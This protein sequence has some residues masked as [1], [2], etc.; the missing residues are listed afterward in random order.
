M[1][2]IFAVVILFWAVFKQ[3]GS[4]LNTWADRYTDREV[5]GTMAT[6][7]DHLKFSKKLTYAKDSIDAYDDQFRLIKEDG[8]VKLYGSGLVSSHGEAK[9]ALE[10]QWEAKGKPG[11][12]PCSVRPVAE[13]RP[14]D[15]D[16]VCETAFE[17]DHFQPIY[18]VLESFEQLRD[19]MND[20]AERVLGKQAVGAGR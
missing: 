18:Y 7:T 11:A 8:K 14:F 2:A 1:L 15:L 3:N 13:W 4:A 12:E 6:V 16:R 9:Y 17:I 20:Y 19:A 10:G 5:T